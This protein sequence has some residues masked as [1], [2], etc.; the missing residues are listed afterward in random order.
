VQ[1]PGLGTSFDDC[2]IARLA[3]VAELLSPAYTFESFRSS[4]WVPCC[5]WQ[6]AIK[7]GPLKLR[8]V[9]LGDSTIIYKTR[10]QSKIYSHGLKAH[11]ES[12]SHPKFQ[13][14]CSF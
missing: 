9:H 12:R 3:G 8:T 2:A 14:N 13:V 11:I 1:A 4:F 6:G 5:K 10:F 7:H